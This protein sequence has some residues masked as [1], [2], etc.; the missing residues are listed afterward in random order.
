MSRAGLVAALSLVAWYY[1]RTIHPGVLLVVTAAVSVLVQPSYL[2]GDVGWLLSFASFAGVMFMAPLL[3]MY[4]YGEKKPGVL[5]QI[6]GE[7]FSAQLMTLPL[8][9]VTF[10]VVSNVALIANLL[11][12]PLVPLAM[13]LTFIT[14]LVAII[15]PAIASFVAL[16]AYWLLSY[17]TWVIEYLAEL[18]WASVEVQI[19]WVA[20]LTMYG[21]LLI[22]LVALKRKTHMNFRKVNIVE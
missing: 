17:M 18:P 1:G 7:T 14:G 6:L 8:I 13:L 15:M 11:V 4:F 5:R 12:L 21:A 2:W 19:D 16:P 9:L 20:G 3:Q 22:V 10:G